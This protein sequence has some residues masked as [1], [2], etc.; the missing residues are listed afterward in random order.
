LPWSGAVASSGAAVSPTRDDPE[1]IGTAPVP[2]LGVGLCCG[3]EQ[4]PRGT[5]GDANGPGVAA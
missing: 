1:E 3:P 4:V 2:I 5:A